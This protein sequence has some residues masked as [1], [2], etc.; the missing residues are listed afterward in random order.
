[1]AGCA[2]ARA[3]EVLLAGL[4]VSALE[5][6]DIDTLT[7]ALF[8]DCVVLLGMDKSCQ[9]GNLPIRKIEA[10]HALLRASLA[11]HG[12]NLVSIH[13]LGHHLGTGKIRPALSAA[14]IPTMAKGA[15]L[16]KDG[17]AILDQSGRI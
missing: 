5:I 13:I 3:A 8:R 2:S 4:D 14:G 7:I 16:L 6:G 12:A 9:A 17:A 1:V 10:W 11:Y 15:I